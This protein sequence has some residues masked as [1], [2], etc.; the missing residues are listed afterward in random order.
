MALDSVIVSPREGLGIATVLTRK[1]RRADLALRVRES[2]QIE[3]PD[4]PHRAA[5]G[6]FAMIGTGPS[7]WLALQ[8]NGGNGFARALK[9]A[10]GDAASISDQSAGYVVSRLSGSNVRDQLAK[11]VPVDLHARAFAVGDAVSTVAGHMNVILWR[12]ED[13]PEGSA[14][15]EIAVFRSFAESLRHDLTVL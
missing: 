13:E 8:E 14:V 9:A 12:L 6:E 5:A 1:G 7:A 3:L 2:L 11:V 10:L 15:F 4:G